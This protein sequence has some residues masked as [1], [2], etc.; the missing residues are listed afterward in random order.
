MYFIFF[1]L[2]VN[3]SSRQTAKDCLFVRQSLSLHNLFICCLFLCVSRVHT[4]QKTV[5]SYVSYSLPN[6]LCLQSLPTSVRVWATHH[7]RPIILASISLC[8][9]SFINVY[10]CACLRHT[11]QQTDHSCTTFFPRC[12][13]NDRLPLSFSGAHTAADS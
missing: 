2:S 10:L 9:I 1:F 4:L 6:S 3:L 11:S 5:H 7:S 13:W 8:L 12:A